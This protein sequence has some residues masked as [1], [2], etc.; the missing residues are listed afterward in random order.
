MRYISLCINISKHR[1]IFC[2]QHDTPAVCIVFDQVSVQ[3]Q[4]SLHRQPSKLAYDYCLISLFDLLVSV[5]CQAVTESDYPSVRLCLF[6]SLFP[7]VTNESVCVPLDTRTRTTRLYTESHFALGCLNAHSSVVWCIFSELLA[8]QY[9]A[10]TTTVNNAK[11]YFAS[12]VLALV[13][14]DDPLQAPGIAAMQ[15]NHHTRKVMWVCHCIK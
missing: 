10:T 11:M 3:N 7:S 13:F 6:V 14:Y 9:T 1:Q 15:T 12:G 2:P 8:A 5:T 4:V